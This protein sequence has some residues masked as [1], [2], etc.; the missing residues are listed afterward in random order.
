MSTSFSVDKFILLR[1][2][3]DIKMLNFIEPYFFYNQIKNPNSSDTQV[4]TAQSYYG[5]SMTEALLS[6][7]KNTV[8]KATGLE[9]FPTYSYYRNY[10]KGDILH[11]HLDRPA[12]EISATLCLGY[13]YSDVEYEW[14][15]FVEGKG[16]VLNPGDMA[17]YRGLECTHWRNKFDPPK[18]NDYQIQT[19]LHYVDIN[20]PY[21][22][23]KYDKRKGL[24]YAKE[25]I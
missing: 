1:Q 4:S 3:V 7:L 2:A 9:L 21:S 15:I 12:C 11:P 23:W 14:P 22:E 17:I 8:E 10:R 20:G 25:H 13:S 6:R 19:F 24:G 5:D 18:D 16:Y